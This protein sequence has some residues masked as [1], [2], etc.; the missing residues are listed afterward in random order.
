MG[1]VAQ[2]ARYVGNVNA[3]NKSVTPT[4]RDELH[5]RYRANAEMNQRDGKRNQQQT[6]RERRVGHD[7]RPRRIPRPRLIAAEVERHAS[8]DRRDDTLG[9]VKDECLQHVGR[10]ALSDCE[11]CFAHRGFVAAVENL[12][13]GCLDRN[14][15]LGD[16]GEPDAM[17]IVIE[18]AGLKALRHEFLA[19]EHI[20]HTGKR[21]RRFVP[22]PWVTRSQI[23]GPN[24]PSVK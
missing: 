3:A 24:R 7:R 11:K 1:G 16:I 15:V 8:R 22:R 19:I 10:I 20:G 13:A 17:A 14:V 5:R 2:T 9:L 4:I 6:D 23:A 18:V 21:P 12:V